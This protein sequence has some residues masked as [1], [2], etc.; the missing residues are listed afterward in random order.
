MDGRLVLLGSQRL[1]EERCLLEGVGNGELARLEGEGKTAVLVGFPQQGEVAG[2]L[3]IADAPR[4][5]AAAAVADLRAHGLQVL[6]L[7]GDNRRTADAVAQRVGIAAHH[8]DL[9]PEEKAALVQDLRR[10]LGSVAMVGDGVNDAP[11]L[12]TA[13][14][15][16]AMG[17]R[18]SDAALETADV[19][20]MS[21]DLRR[22][23]DAVR[24]GRAT[25]RVIRENIGFALAVKALVLGLAVAG[26][27]SLWAAVAADMGASLLVIA[28]GLRLLRK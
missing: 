19:V 18:G 22:V 8:A 20:L 13:S 15:G 4:P 3:G 9:L 1:F 7:T 27:A 12:A 26:Y 14:V 2:I 24:L 6:L 21:D 25:R 5:E 11:A 17:E 10:R 28:N 23:A 16:I